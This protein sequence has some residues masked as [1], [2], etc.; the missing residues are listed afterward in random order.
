MCKGLV[1]LGAVHVADCGRDLAVGEELGPVRKALSAGS[2]HAEPE[3]I[4]A[5]RAVPYRKR[6]ACAARECGSGESASKSLQHSPSCH[7]VH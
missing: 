1:D 4:A 6:R 2:Y 5:K 7:A 3:A